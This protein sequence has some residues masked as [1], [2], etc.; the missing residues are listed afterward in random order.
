LKKEQAKK[1]VKWKSE[2]ECHKQ[3]LCILQA[4]IDETEHQKAVVEKK[5][6]DA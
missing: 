5:K 6:G 2:Q 3:T 4:Q 1:E